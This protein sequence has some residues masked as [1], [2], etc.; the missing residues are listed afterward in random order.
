[1]STTSAEV[2]AAIVEHAVV[3]PRA[4][5]RRRI[6]TGAVL[7]LVGLVAL[8]GWGLGSGTEDA[9]F[10]FSGGASVTLPD[11]TVAGTLT[12]AVL[13][14]LVIALG[15]FQIVKGFRLKRTPLLVGVTVL[16]FVLAFLCWAMSGGPGASIDVVELLQQTVFLATPLILGALAGVLGERSGVVNVAIEGQF[17]AGAFAGALVA[18]MVGN[19]GVG[20]LAAVLAGALVGWLLA[21]FAIRYRVN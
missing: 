5:L 8:L 2:P 1:M 20:V 6:G 11:L 13:G 16:F 21:V 17:L 9:T 10:R 12:P 15:V 3:E 7:I 19:L 18:T 4:S 14:A